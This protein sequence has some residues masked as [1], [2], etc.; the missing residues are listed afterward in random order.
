[1][2]IDLRGYVF[3]DTIHVEHPTQGNP[4]FTS[5]ERGASYKGM[6]VDQAG[7]NITATAQTVVHSVRAF[8]D[9]DPID[10]EPGIQPGDRIYIDPHY[11]HLVASVTVWDG[12]RYGVR[13]FLE[14]V[15]D[16]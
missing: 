9:A 6:I 2:L 8:L 13:S 12:E 11:P 10:G 5:W 15:C 7:S 3:N 4:R 14:V 1:M 16:G